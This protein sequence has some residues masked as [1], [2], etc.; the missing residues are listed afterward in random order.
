MLIQLFFQCALMMFVFMIGSFFIG[1]IKQNNS[2][3]ADVAWGIGFI[4]IALY[5]LAQQPYIVARQILVTM[6][7]CFWGLRI[8][9]FLLWRGWGKGLDPRFAELQ[10]NWGSLLPLYSFIFI[11]MGQG[12]ITLMMSTSII[13]IINNQT[14]GLNIID[15]IGASIW[16]SGFCFEIVS[17][18]QLYFYLK[19]PVKKYPIMKEGLWRYSRHPNYFGE[20]LMWW[21]IW[22][23]SLSTPYALISIISPLTITLMLLYVSGIPAAEKQMAHIPEYEQYKKETPMLIPWFPV[24]KKD[25]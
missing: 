5:S 4:M 22:V 11:F 7:I 10:K 6:L 2:M 14:S 3:S 13:C 18:L 12:F 17:D 25:K 21:G 15:I 8:S 20:M 1:H 23:I 19:N 24:I 16:L 9:I